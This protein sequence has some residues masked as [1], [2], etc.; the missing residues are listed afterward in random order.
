M[1]SGTSANGVNEN[2]VGIGTL[3]PSQPLSVSGTVSAST[4]FNSNLFDSQWVTLRTADTTTLV[5]Y[6]AG[7]ATYAGDN[8]MTAVCHRALYS[9][10]GSP[11]NNY[12]T[13]VGT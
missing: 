12:N 11:A 8:N 13:A 2:K 10:D 7:G 6:E 5:G 4:S 3:S 1:N 9:S